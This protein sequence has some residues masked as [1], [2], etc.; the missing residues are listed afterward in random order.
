MTT[1]NDILDKV[2]M[3][4][5]EREC[6]LA[7]ERFCRENFD[8]LPLP[9]ENTQFDR[10]M[11][12][13]SKLMKLSS[14]DEAIVARVTERMIGD[15]ATA[16]SKAVL[17]VKDLVGTTRD[18]AIATWQDLL[19]GMQWRP[20]VPAGAT[21]GLGSQLVSLGSFEKETAD[22]KIQVN[23]GW[24][25]DKDQLRLLLNAKDTADNGMPD[26]EVRILESERGVV[27]TRTTNLD[28]A[29]VAPQISVGPGEYQIQVL[30]LDKVI[31][32]PFF[33]I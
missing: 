3:I 2:M 21:R 9:G 17:K 8:Y 32:T 10:A 23:L 33:K 5:D 25:V 24:L 7:F 12:N 4:E 18:A 22:T 29:V 26:V 14:R 6:S 30:W 19:L 11:W 31:E 20:M 15:T 1:L 13:A 28:G 27:F 16:T